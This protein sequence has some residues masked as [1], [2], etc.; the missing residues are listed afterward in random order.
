MSPGIVAESDLTGALKSEYVF[1]AGRRTA[2]KDFP[3]G[4]VS[5]YFSDYLQTASVITNAAGVITEDEDYYPWGMDLPLVDNDSNHYKH[6]G[7]DRDTET[8]NDYYGA[9]YYSPSLSR[10]LSPD[11]SSTPVPV[12]YADLTNP[13]T[14][15]QYAY[16][17][18]NPMSFRDPDGHCCDFTGPVIDFTLGLL[19]AWGSDNLAGAGRMEQI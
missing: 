10:F 14:L 1:F 5:Y 12:P 13:Q 16:V 8:G 18:N 11:W 17:H 7:K 19:N 4:A 6:N 15:N 9:R 3:G 2:R